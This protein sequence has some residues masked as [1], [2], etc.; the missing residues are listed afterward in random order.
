MATTSK[1]PKDILITA[2]RVAQRSIKAYSHRYSPKKFTQHQLFAVLVLKSFLKNDYRGVAKHLNDCHALAE[3]I[4]LTKIPHFTT[5]QKASRRL[6]K[7]APVRVL[8]DETV[9]LQMGRR[10]RVPTTAIDSTGLECSSASGYFVRRR[11]KVGE[12]WKKVI[13]HRYPK[14][15]IGCGNC[16]RER[17][18]LGDV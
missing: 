7:M 15:G 2:Y 9:R 4:E 6:L 1:S 3:A 14:L 8:L 10:L 16:G 12:S 18:Y 5:L 13:Y 17:G 11:K